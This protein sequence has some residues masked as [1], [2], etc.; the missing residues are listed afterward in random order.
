L[1]KPRQIRI[2]LT[3]GIGDLEAWAE[4]LHAIAAEKGFVQHFQDG[5]KRFGDHGPLCKLILGYIEKP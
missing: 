2:Q 5:P 4:D 3:G 1:P